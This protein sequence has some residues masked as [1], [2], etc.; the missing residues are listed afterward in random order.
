MDN[1]DQPAPPE[2]LFVFV[3]AHHARLREALV[4]LIEQHDGYTA[5][6]HWPLWPVF[7]PAAVIAPTSDLSPLECAAF[8]KAG[9]QPIVLAPR[10]SAAERERY[11]DGHAIYL[12]MDVT[13][14]ASLF[15]ALEGAETFDEAH[16]PHRTAS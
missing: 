12:A 4:H 13:S 11:E 7:T 1:A 6:S 15:A 14:S 5:V 8:H 2:K 16:H 9:M 10:P 3:I